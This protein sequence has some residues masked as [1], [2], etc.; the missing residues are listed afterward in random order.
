MILASI[1]GVVGLIVFVAVAAAVGV[2]LFLKKN[3]KTA[4]KIN[5]VVDKV[6]N[7]GSK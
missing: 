2:V 7:I 3:K 4:A 5:D 1:V 6:G